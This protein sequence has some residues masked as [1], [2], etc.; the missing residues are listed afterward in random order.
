MTRIF[1]AILLVLVCLAVACTETNKK[2]ASY[3]PSLEKYKEDT[4]LMLNVSQKFKEERDIQTLRKVA[5][6]IQQSRAMACRDFN[7]EC[8]IFSDYMN[9]VIA[10]SEDGIISP[11]EHRE[12]FN[13]IERLR[14]AVRD[15]V[16]ILQREENNR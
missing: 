12:M 16:N 11:S 10:A 8:Q 13:E 15:G 9:L 2:E 6:S 5:V 7:K 4:A 1:Y 14:K 3:H